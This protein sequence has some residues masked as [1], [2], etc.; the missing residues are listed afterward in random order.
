MLLVP[1][2][3][4][5][6]KGVT[7]LAEVIDLAHQQDAG[8]PLHKG[9]KEECGLHPGDALAHLLISPAQ[10]DDTWTNALDFNLRYLRDDHVVSPHH[11]R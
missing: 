9:H 2:S 11:T 1:K 10:F 7:I 4:Q 8:L 6:R 3:H 5:V